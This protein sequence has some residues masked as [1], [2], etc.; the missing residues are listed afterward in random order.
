MTRRAAFML[1]GLADMLERLAL[2]V[3][4]KGA[5]LLRNH[6]RNGMADHL[7]KSASVK[8]FAPFHAGS[9]ARD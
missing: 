6:A 9:N 3:A 7:A 2:A 4:A 8:M 5:V 1:I